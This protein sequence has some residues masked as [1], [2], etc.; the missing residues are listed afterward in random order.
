MDL[1]NHPWRKK[2]RLVKL[3]D[4]FFSDIIPCTACF[5]EQGLESYN[6]NTA[7]FKEQGLESYNDNTACFKEQGL[8][9]YEYNNKPNDNTACFKE[10]VLEP[11]EYNKQTNETNYLLY[12]HN[13]INCPLA[14]I[15]DLYDNAINY[16][17]M[18]PHY[19][20]ISKIYFKEWNNNQY[21]KFIENVK[22]QENIKIK[23]FLENDKIKKILKN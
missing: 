19:I 18:Y 9:S 11:Y 15:G 12:K 21:I 13:F 8:E 7:C 10:Q 23:K 14:H 3:H 1:L 16:A 5:K 20:E 2:N 6:D 4:L 17:S 22:I